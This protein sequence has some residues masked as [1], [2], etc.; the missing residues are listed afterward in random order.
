LRAVEDLVS[1]RVIACLILAGALGALGAGT[2]RADG[3]PASDILY[4]QDVF[5]TYSK[6]SPDLVAAL[7]TEVAKANTAGYRI[8]VAVIANPTDLGSV[9]SLFN[10]PEVYAR[11][12]GAEL[13]LFYT[14]RLLVVMPAGFGVYRNGAATDAEEAILAGV[15]ID[16]ADPDSLTRAAAEAV[17]KLVAAANPEPPKDAVPPKVKAFPAK[18]Q[19]G[20]VAKLR[21]S[22][23]DDSGKSRETVRVYGPN[24]VLYATIPTRLRPARLATVR[25]VAWRVP[26]KINGAGLKFC[27]LA[28]DAAGNQSRPGCAPIRVR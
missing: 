23:S 7:T 9:P 11:F 6:P 28:R 21:Y 10:Q 17:Q 8:K 14:N 19:R 24:L 1:I 15:K 25:A 20:Q 3:D 12:L 22:V 5:V 18:A 4:L 27:V 13:G 16:G 26:R 2:A